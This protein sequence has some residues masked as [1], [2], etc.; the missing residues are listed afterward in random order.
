MTAFLAEITV[1]VSIGGF[2][3]QVA[4]TSRIHRSMGMAFALLLLLSLAGRHR[5]SRTRVRSAVGTGRGCSSRHFVTR[6]T[7]PRVRCCSCR[8]PRAAIPR[9]AV[10]RR[11]DGSVREG[12]AALLFLVLIQPWGLGLDWR[13]L[14]YAR[15]VMTGIWIVMALVARRDISAHSVPASV[16]ARLRRTIRD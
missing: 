3:V 8:C 16:P 7:R 12:V 14:S 11:D 9:Q 15:L 5:H 2:I 10:H 13:R 6:W 4:L 1:C